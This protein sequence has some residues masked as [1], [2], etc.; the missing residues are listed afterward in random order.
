MRDRERI[1]SAAIGKTQLLLVPSVHKK[2]KLSQTAGI[3]A[4]QL[5]LVEQVCTDTPRVAIRMHRVQVQVHH[6]RRCTRPCVER[7]HPP[8]STG[9][10]RSAGPAWSEWR[11][12][13]CDAK[14]VKSPSLCWLPLR[15]GERKGPEE[16]AGV[17]PPPEGG[18]KALQYKEA[19]EGSTHTYTHNTEAV[20]EEK[21]IKR[22]RDAWT[23]RGGG[24]WSGTSEKTQQPVLRGLPEEDGEEPKGEKSHSFNISFLGGPVQRLGALPRLCFCF[25]SLSIYILGLWPVLWRQRFR[26][27]QPA[28]HERDSRGYK[29][30][31]RHDKKKKTQESGGYKTYSSQWGV[32]TFPMPSEEER[33][34]GKEV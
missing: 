9:H 23:R 25:C 18:H 16:S 31:A 14:H 21:K 34:G 13:N 5:K 27:S 7:L 28:A 2:G 29:K 24:R 3:S 11:A 19:V 1:H 33:G 26:R 6:A 8:P 12:G 15:S 22:K 10:H 30:K 32:T 4:R 17:P 20:E